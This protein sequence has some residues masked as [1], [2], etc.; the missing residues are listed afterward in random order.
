MRTFSYFLLI[1]FT[2][3][4]ARPTGTSTLLSVNG[5]LQH[6]F[7][8][9]RLNILL[10]LLLATC[11]L[12]AQ[13]AVSGFQKIS[14]EQGLSN[15]AVYSLLQD[16]QGFIWV[17]TQ[18]GLDR[19]DGYRFAHY[20]R[21]PGDPNSLADNFINCLHE[22]R[23]GAI[24]VGN[25]K[26]LSRLDK[27]TE[28][29][30]NFPSPGTTQ[31]LAIAEDKTG[32]LWLGTS[33]GLMQFDILKKEYRRIPWQ[34][35]GTTS[36]R[37]SALLFDGQGTLW[38]AAEAGLLRLDPDSNLSISNFPIPR[39]PVR[40]LCADG[41]A[42]LWLGTSTGL[43][44]FDK[45]SGQAQAVG[46][47]NEIALVTKDSRGRLLAGSLKGIEVFDPASKTL[48][49]FLKDETKGGWFKASR[50]QV[51]LEDR[52]QTYW[53]G[54]FSD[55][56]YRFD[57]LQKRFRHFRHE[58]GNPLSLSDNFTIALFEDS[59]GYV[60]AGTDANLNLQNP[61]DGRFTTFSA[62]PT[63]MVRSI[64]EDK[65]GVMW[66]GVPTGV[67]RQERG[68][69]PVW[70][71][72]DRNEPLPSCPGAAVKTIFQDKSGE[73]WFGG[74]NGLF[75]H[76]PGSGTFRQVEL[77]RL[78]ADSTMIYHVTEDGQS[79]LW[80]STS[81]GLVRLDKSRSDIH[82]FFHDPADPASLCD[83]NISSVAVAAN[84]QIWVASYDGGFEKYD[85]KTGNFRHFNQRQGLPD[86]K[87]WGIVEDGSGYL[88]LSHCRGLSRFDPRTETFRHFDMSD[89]LQDHEF[90]IGSFHRGKKTGR[91]Y[92]GGAQGFNVFHPDSLRF[93]ETPPPVVFTAFRYHTGDPEETDF[94]KIPGISGIAG[95]SLDYPV[96]TI[97]C[98]FAAL[99]FRQPGKNR[100]SYRLAGAQDNWV[101]L[102][103]K[104]E[105]T[106][107]NLRPGT[108]RLHVKAS[109][110]DGVWNEEG[111]TLTITLHPPWWATWW[112]YVL[113]A[114]AIGTAVWLFYRNRL[115]QKM[116]EQET[117]RLKE[118]DEFKRRFFTNITHEFRTPL[119]VILGNL[120][121]EKQKILEMEKL[122]NW[123]IG[124]P[125][126]IISQFLNFQISKNTLTRRSAESLLRLIN[127]ILDLAKVDSNS[128]KI[129]YV[130]SDVLSY[131]QYVTES[132]QSLAHS[133]NIRL[134]LESTE[135]E[136]VMDYDPER[137]LSIVHNLLSNAIKFT[138]PGGQVTLSIG[139]R[140]EGRGM[141]S[142]VSSSLIPHP[143]SLILTVSDTGV[144]IPAED[145][146]KIFDR[147]FQGGNTAASTTGA[148]RT[149]SSGIGLSLTR[150]LVK[151]MGGDISVESEVGKG[152]TFAVRLPIRNEATIAEA[153]L[154]RPFVT[155]A[156]S[157]EEPL[158]MPTGQI[159]GESELPYIL[160]VEDNPDVVEYLA[161]CLNSHQLAEPAPGHRG[162]GSGVKYQLDFAYNG[163]AG[164]E[165]ALET[166]PDL[167]ISDVMMPEK[168]GFELVE[169]LKNDERT[170]HIPIVLLTAKASVESRIAGLRRGADAYLSKPFH[171]EELL[172]T[173]ANLLEVR[174]KLQAKYGDWRLAVGDSTA[175]SSTTNLQSPITDPE[176]EFL[177]RVIAI[178]EEH[179]DDSEFGV[180]QLSQKLRLSQSQLYRKVKA[181]TDLSTAAFIRRVRLRKGKHLLEITGLTVSEV[182][183]KVGF[184][185]PGYFSDAFLE[186]FGI[187]PN[188]MRK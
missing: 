81:N 15:Q 73:L 33:G 58:P 152:T 135:R 55:G 104:T 12:F 9:Q 47:P 102:G 57:P 111:A 1:S 11:R 6:Y 17:G 82:Y 182:A 37:I 61:A 43:Y 146:P 133:R 120:E 14:I 140:D 22:D 173:L 23:A 10:L 69:P 87:I 157:R 71:R 144:G 109:N 70:L 77:S 75:R 34:P 148:G 80:V 30:Q 108:Y 115:R 117:L 103:N 49:P 51:L 129:N 156:P 177:H 147:F 162:E 4:Y 149:G 143:S 154:M 89:G 119:T 90:T 98:E 95:V 176:D 139:L 167:I 97:V 64:F 171:R 35:A 137:L 76:Q 134:K 67:I 94:R 62:Q 112:A 185:T 107:A 126:N 130:Q 39:F 125:G 52:N 132:L 2:H 32:N 65:D 40:S 46:E 166:I 66:V 151:A 164:I 36:S 83:N 118:L 59:R 48:R 85:P 91:L 24:W 106:F 54:T 116:R 186:E 158:E 163:S 50:P 21:R 128:L 18:S 45:K 188:A 187:R 5:W 84:G 26:G 53:L 114:L 179:L 41:E 19:F 124:W 3:L 127:Q 86:E 68:K 7:E 29:F 93:N 42:V 38:A 31:I 168:D 16:R 136:I 8:K 56:I 131:L 183:Y 13:P 88:W 165:K 123:A 138:P 175:Q 161:A 78:K 27:T 44:R 153:P 180:P 101:D 145:L 174:K 60:W 184:D 122:G 142:G 170:S 150:E 110:N 20:D 178:L 105:V 169:T 113:Y 79:N 181:L 155:V 172:V 72:Y 74:G 159:S 141:K 100:F 96:Q 63:G 25:R 28:Q 160:I 92:F 121:M 99:N